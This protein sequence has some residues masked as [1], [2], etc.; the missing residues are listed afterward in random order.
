MGVK[1]RQRTAQ[2]HQNQ[3]DREVESRIQ[4]ALERPEKLEEETKEEENKL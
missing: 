1:K 4:E 3:V 2:W